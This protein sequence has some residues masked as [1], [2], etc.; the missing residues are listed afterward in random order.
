LEVAEANAIR[1]KARII[2]RTRE[3]VWSTA[4]RRVVDFILEAEPG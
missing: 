3:E 4:L 1:Y 2:S